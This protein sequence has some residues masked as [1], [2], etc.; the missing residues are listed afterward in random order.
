MIQL[1]T[2]GSGAA[3]PGVEGVTWGILLSLKLN[4]STEH[5]KSKQHLMGLRPI[6]LLCEYPHSRR[7]TKPMPSKWFTALKT[8]QSKLKISKN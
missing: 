4:R 8:L 5:L 2:Q 3:A 6:V 1:L 7:F